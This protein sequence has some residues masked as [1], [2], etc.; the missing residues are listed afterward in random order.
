MKILATL[1]LLCGT[2]FAQ[3][4]VQFETVQPRY[5]VGRYELKFKAK[6]KNVSNKEI[7]GVKFRAAFFDAVADRH[8]V[9]GD[10][11]VSSQKAKPSESKTSYWRDNYEEK[12]YGRKSAEIWAKTVLFADGTR[13]EDD[14][15]EKCKGK[16]K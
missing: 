6:W 7:T 15:T 3:C 10:D 13:W 14:G 12:Y 5:A 2:M 1:V 11:W 16:S 9:I 4:P 8:P